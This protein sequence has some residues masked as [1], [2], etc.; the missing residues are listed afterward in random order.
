MYSITDLNWPLEI[1]LIV[2][3][4]MDYIRFLTIILTHILLMEDT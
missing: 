2:D 4:K 3:V 1:S